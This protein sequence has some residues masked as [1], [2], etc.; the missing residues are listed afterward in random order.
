MEI[1]FIIICI[2]ILIAMPL[3]TG[4]IRKTRTAALVSKLYFVVAYLLIITSI[5]LFAA[6]NKALY[7]TY[8]ICVMCGGSGTEVEGA[9][10]MICQGAGE[11]LTSHTSFS[12]PW[13]YPICMIVLGIYTAIFSFALRFFAEHSGID[14]R[15]STAKSE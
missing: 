8:E 14:S 6:T 9:Q 13:L 11:I 4:W 3:F 7:N 1:T 2:A 12:I 15:S 5:V 10:C